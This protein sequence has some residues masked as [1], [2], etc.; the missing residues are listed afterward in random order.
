MAKILFCIKGKSGIEVWDI[1][2]ENPK[3]CTWFLALHL[4]TTGDRKWDDSIH[5]YLDILGNLR[6]SRLATFHRECAA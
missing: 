2:E 1:R 3:G 5:C 4:P 6:I